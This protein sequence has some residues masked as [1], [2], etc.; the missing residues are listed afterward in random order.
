MYPAKCTSEVTERSN[1]N[2]IRESIKLQKPS[3]WLPTVNEA[4][5]PEA[6]TKDKSPESFAGLSDLLSQAT[7]SFPQERR[8]ILTCE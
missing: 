5:E 6:S 7:D 4:K 8:F 3:L 2:S 1:I